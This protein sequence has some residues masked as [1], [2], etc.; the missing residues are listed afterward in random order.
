MIHNYTKDDKSGE[1][2]AVSH[3]GYGEVLI[4]VQEEGNQARIKLTIEQATQLANKI[5][6]SIEIAKNQDSV[7][8]MLQ[9]HKI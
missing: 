9:K 4:Q 6:Q 2:W 1:H 7:E 3:N 5:L 8:V